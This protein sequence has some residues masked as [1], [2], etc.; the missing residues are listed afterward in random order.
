[1]TRYST[2]SSKPSHP[3]TEKS[4]A[5]VV[6]LVAAIVDLINFSKEVI[7]LLRDIAIANTQRS[8]LLAEITATNALLHDLER[9]AKSAEWQ[10]TLEAIERKD[11]PLELFKSI[12]SVLEGKSRPSK[13]RFGRVGN[14]VMWHFEKDEFED[15][16]RKLERCKATL[17][18]TLGV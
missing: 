4:M 3:L 2:A 12:L 10:R 8:A 9:K 18:L 11:G 7:D 5:D 16:L 17:S 1:V 13:G 15:I 6:R 14:A